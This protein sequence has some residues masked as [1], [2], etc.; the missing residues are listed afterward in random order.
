MSEEQHCHSC[1]A[2]EE[3]AAAGKYDKVPAG[4]SGVVY[5]CPMCPGVRDVR[6]SGCPVCGMSLEPEGAAPGDEDTSE[7]DDMTRRFWVSML[8]TT[9]LF[10][11]T[12]GDMLPGLSSRAVVPDAWSHWLQLL[13]ALPVVLWCGWPFL[14][15]AAQSLRTRNLNM[16]TLIGLGVSVAFLYSLV[17]TL[18]PQLFPD[19]FRLESG[20]VGVYFEAAAVITTLVLF[21]QVLELRARAP[22]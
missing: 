16:F 20:E 5:I 2:G 19:A 18:A 12:M 3:H 14:Q 17:A 22:H 11:Y 15:R 9:P 8:F 4:Y 10:V 7:L 1:H 21:G 13:L 6:N